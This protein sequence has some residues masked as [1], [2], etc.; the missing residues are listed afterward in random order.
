MMEAT[1]TKPSVLTKPLGPRFR[2]SGLMILVLGA[3]LSL[4]LM[5]RA[6]VSV[7]GGP[8]YWRS[9]LTRWLGVVMAPCGAALSLALLIQVFGQF[10]HRESP[11]RQ[12]W[13]LC[14]RL[15]AL[16]LL[17]L[18]L[19]E[20][21]SLLQVVPPSSWSANWPPGRLS[22]LVLDSRQRILPV[23]EG[24]LMVGLV[25]GMRPRRARSG[26]QP[27]RLAAW[28]MAV[29][30]GVGGAM[31]VA[32]MMTIP[33]L[34]LIAVE[35]VENA[36]LR[37]GEG[38]GGLLASPAAAS[39][40]Q[41]LADRLNGIVPEV[42]LALLLVL[43]A[44]A[45]LSSSL[46]RAAAD[47]VRAGRGSWRDLCFGLIVAAACL[48]AGSHLVFRTLPFVQPLA[49][50]GL[51]MNVGAWELR[52]I[53]IGVGC[54]SAGLLAH[55]LAPGVDGVER[56][57]RSRPALNWQAAWL[58]KAMVAVLLLVVILSSLEEI[59]TRGGLTGR[60]LPGWLFGWLVPWRAPSAHL[61]D[62]L[63][64]NEWAGMV[65]SDASLWFP[66]LII[67]W[68]GWR[69]VGLLILA[70]NPAPA[71]FDHLFHSAASA[72]RFVGYWC[73][74]SA[75]LMAAAPALALTGVLV[76]HHALAM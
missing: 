74:F 72:R 19:A 61:W 6:H 5:S 65:T 75:L 21:S 45:W 12:A 63:R 29:L 50:E 47:E 58:L 30:A 68:L 55:I 8:S 33:Y 71:P 18:L 69:S 66:A 62:W 51:A 9:P 31:I 3:G 22:P 15:A 40:P 56:E 38:S 76:L 53:V 35:M 16:A 60:F 24:L 11:G 46:R 44:G 14:W 39:L 25:L 1:I 10:E 42:G 67:P 2:L 59:E 70:R 13:P 17:A 20:E 28:L 52:V 37:P 43:F 54:F 4:G 49:L 34:V 64:V 73:A 7:G 27:T 26:S 32:T 48:F 41:G 36:M 23:A 57:T